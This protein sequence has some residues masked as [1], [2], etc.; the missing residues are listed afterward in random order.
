MDAVT[1]NQVANTLAP[2]HDRLVKEVFGF[3]VRHEP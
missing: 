3:V 2:G 1:F